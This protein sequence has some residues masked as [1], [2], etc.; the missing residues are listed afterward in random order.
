MMFE[1]LSDDELVIQ[2]TSA[3][4]DKRRL[5]TRI[6]VLLAEVEEREIYLAVA[7]SSMWDYARRFLLMSHGCAYRFIAGARLCKKY[8]WMIDRLER[9]DLHLT[10]LA[11]IKSFITPENVEELVAECA[12]KKRADVDL[13]LR[14][15]FGIDAT[16]TQVGCPLPWDAELLRMVERAAELASHSIPM[17]DRLGLTKAAYAL[18]IAYLEKTRRAKTDNPRPAPTGPTKSI[19]R[20]ATRIMF[21]RY[22]EQ[23]AFV[24][25]RTG[26]RCPSR[27]YLEHDHIHMRIFGATH[28]PDELRPLCDAHNRWLAKQKL[29]GEYVER[30]IHV[31][32]RKQQKKANNP[33]TT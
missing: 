2:L 25:E 7:A 9:G 33:P 13:V 14:R 23:C 24:D 28:D 10:T 20:A 27:A 15:W 1:H 12:G 3:C 19:P 8:P 16:R 4:F 30:C 32:Q 18:F 26:A 31:R 6:L 17:N 21:E 29:G 22:G 5:T 11:H